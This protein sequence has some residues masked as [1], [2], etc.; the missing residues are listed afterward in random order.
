MKIKKTGKRL[1]PRDCHPWF[2]ANEI[3]W[4]KLKLGNAI[5]IPD[6]EAESILKIFGDTITVVVSTDHKTD[7]SEVKNT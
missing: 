1:L 6:K 2:T 7:D 3:E 5:S 4:D